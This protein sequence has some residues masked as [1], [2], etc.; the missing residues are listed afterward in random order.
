MQVVDWD[1]KGREA[2]LSAS[3]LGIHLHRYNNGEWHAHAADR[4]Q[5]RAV[6]EKRLE[7]RRGGAHEGAAASSRRS[8]RGTA[9]RS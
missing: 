4:G 7:R 8:S 1:G 3:F 2:L 9:T 6:A 5:S